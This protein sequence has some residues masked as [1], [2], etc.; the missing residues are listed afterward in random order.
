M[1]AILFTAYAGFPMLNAK[2]HA[3]QKTKI[4]IIG[5]G[6]GGLAMAIRLLQSQ[7]SDFFILEKSNDV[8]GTWRENRYPGAACDVQSHMYSLS[9]APKTDWSKRYAEAP[10]IFDYI[11]DITNQYQIKNYCKFNHEVTHVQYD[12]LRHIWTLN[13]ANQP[14]LEAQFVAFASGPLHIPQIPHIQGIEK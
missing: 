3:I 10:E 1:P 11:Q 14:S 12:E 5:A 8:G 2:Q 4:A 9:F 13:F 6:F 7:Q